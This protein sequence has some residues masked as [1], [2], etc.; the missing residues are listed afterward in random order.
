MDALD[1]HRIAEGCRR[2][3]PAV[4]PTARVQRCRSR[5]AGHQEA[6]VEA[7]DVLLAITLN[8][9]SLHGN[10]EQLIEK[11]SGED[12]RYLVVVDDGRR[13]PERVRL[14]FEAV[15][16]YDVAYDTTGLIRS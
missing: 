15:D 7:A 1:K 2:S 4:H 11:R 14:S 13:E 12:G 6:G 3:P 16:E 8:V 5:R 10:H 9:A